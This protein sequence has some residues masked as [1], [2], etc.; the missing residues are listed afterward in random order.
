MARHRLRRE[1]YTV[2][3]VCALPIEQEMLDEEHED[4]EH[5]END[6]NLYSLGRIGDHNIVIVC[7]PAGLIGNNPGAAVAT[8]M[9]ATF[10]SVR[11][12]LIVGIGGGVPSAESDIRLGDVVVSQPHQ[13]YGGVIQYDFVK[14]TPSGFQRTG[15]LNSPPLILLSTVAPSS[16][17]TPAREQFYKRSR[18]ALL[19]G[20]FR[21]LMIRPSYKQ[22]EDPYISHFTLIARLFLDRILCTLSLSRSNR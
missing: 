4:L 14:A 7:L 22:T 19:F 3:W 15:F 13:C 12:G 20:P 5:D 18:L 17:G 9:K 8:Q 6:N 21:F 2:G 16:C 10:R 11:F 1:E